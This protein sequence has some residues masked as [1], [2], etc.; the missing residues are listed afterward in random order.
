M[1]SAAPG[2][3][4]A[5]VAEGYLIVLTAEGNELVRAEAF[6]A[7]EFSVRSLLVGDF[8]EQGA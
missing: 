7:V 3:R 1:S 2:R 6:A 4:L 8:D 5:T